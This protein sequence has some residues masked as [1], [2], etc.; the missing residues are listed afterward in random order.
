VIGCEIPVFW[1]RR[2]N[3]A[4]VSFTC[5]L[6]GCENRHGWPEGKDLGGH[7]VSHCECWPQGYYIKLEAE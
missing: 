6:C 5:P 3:E 4:Q 7:R 1:V 2:V